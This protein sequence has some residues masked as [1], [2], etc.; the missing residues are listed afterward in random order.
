MTVPPTITPL[1]THHAGLHPHSV[2]DIGYLAASTSSTFSADAQHS[3]G[4]AGGERR[5]S[6]GG[7]G[8]GMGMGR[9]GGAAGGR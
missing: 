3:H 5:G 9:A 4:C 6:A 7:G 2:L 8:G 1:P